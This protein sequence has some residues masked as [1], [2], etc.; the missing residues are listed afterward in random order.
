MICFFS[1]IS[2]NRITLVQ[3]MPKDVSLENPLEL[4]S[5]LA[6]IL[7]EINSSYSINS[8][9]LTDQNLS[10]ISNT[11]SK[12]PKLASLVLQVSI[13][14][15]YAIIIDWL[16][17][18][19]NISNII[20]MQDQTGFITQ[21]YY[22]EKG[23]GVLFHAVLAN[24]LEAIK[25]SLS[26]VTVAEALRNPINFCVAIDLLKLAIELENIEIISELYTVLAKDE[27][28][29]S[30]LITACRA[31]QTNTVILLKK[32][33]THPNIHQTANPFETTSLCSQYS[34]I[35][36][37]AIDAGAE[38]LDIFI[39]EYPELSRK[40]HL[41]QNELLRYA[42]N[43]QNVQVIN[44][45]L[46]FE[47]VR[48]NIHTLY[49]KEEWNKIVNTL[50]ES[51]GALVTIT[52]RIPFNDICSTSEIS[53]DDEIPQKASESSFHTCTH[54]RHPETY[55]G[56]T[57]GISPTT[58]RPLLHYHSFNVLPVGSHVGNKDDIGIHSSAMNETQ[59]IMP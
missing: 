54:L 12:N 55:A 27:M 11:L 35:L 21:Q 57:T 8:P 58:I 50:N 33:L 1:R 24:H 44:R 5:N 7:R 3:N 13:K 43:T 39:D 29:K 56:V 34:R 40:L 14:Y 51:S 41:G 47:N 19:E 59:K 18:M 31:N 2:P 15:D 23:F 28:T 6:Q 25:K 45:L 36:Y 17:S 42:V 52:E 22:D 53:F 16:F 37:A 10:S 32:L 20:M 9:L 48:N 4:E 26:L 46:Q 30:Y 38:V 49:S